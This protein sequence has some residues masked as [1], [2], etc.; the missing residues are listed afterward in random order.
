VTVNGATLGTFTPS[1]GVFVFAQAGGDSVQFA[2]TK[3]T[4]TTHYIQAPAL[5]QGGDGNDTLD[6]RGSNAANMLVGGAGTDVLYGGLG[7]DI[8]IGGAGADTLRG[9]QGEDVLIGNSTAHDDHLN[10]LLALLEEWSR[11]DANYTT[12][13]NHLLGEPGGLNGD[14]IL[15]PSTLGDDAAIDLLY[16]ESSLDF[17]FATAGKDKINDLSTGEWKISL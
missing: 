4:G 17:F 7:R 11:T 9:G 5:L 13:A 16:G 1:G 15:D 8:L 6:A 14:T 3:I 10:A 2:S 12:R